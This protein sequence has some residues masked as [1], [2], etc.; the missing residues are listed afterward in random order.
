MGVYC[1]HI[2]FGAV[3]FNERGNR[4]LIKGKLNVIYLIF[5]L[6]ILNGLIAGHH[7]SGFS[8][9]HRF[10]HQ[11]LVAPAHSQLRRGRRYR[12]AVHHVQRD[13]AA[14]QRIHIGLNR[15]L[16][17]RL[18]HPCQRDLPGVHAFHDR[19]VRSGLCLCGNAG[20]DRRNSHKQQKR[21]KT[22]PFLHINH[23]SK[24]YSTYNSVG[25]TM[26]KT[27]MMMITDEIILFDFLL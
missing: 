26:A 8:Q 7:V 22:N 4:F 1:F 5:I 25:I 11:I 18:R 17:L 14:S 6:Q 16:R 13:H 21:Q 27:R 20:S 12:I 15:L 23:S 10:A 19:V 24:H 2:I 9:I 3:V